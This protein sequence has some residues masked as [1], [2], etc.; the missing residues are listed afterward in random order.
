MGHRDYAD[1][2]ILAKLGLRGIEVAAL[3]RQEPLSEPSI[4]F[5]QAAASG[6]Q[7]K[8]HGQVVGA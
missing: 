7:L 4:L 3:R 5:R 6:Q 1:L 2:M 8:A